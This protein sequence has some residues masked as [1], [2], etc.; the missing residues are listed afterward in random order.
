M[1]AAADPLRCFEQRRDLLFH[2][3][4]AYERV[5]RDARHVEGQ[6][7]AGNKNITLP[8]GVKNVMNAQGIRTTVATVKLCLNTKGEPTTIQLIKGTG[9]PEA[10]AKIKREMQEWR[11]RP[12]SVNG[13]LVPICTSIIFNY[14]LN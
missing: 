13:K 12:Y 10:D 8:D 11:Y 9:F 2:H 3:H 1:R 14:R 6:R 7:I 5:L 4:L